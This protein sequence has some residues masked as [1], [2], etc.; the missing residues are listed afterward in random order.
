MKL[1]RSRITTEIE[2][3]HNEL[4]SMIITETKYPIE[5]VQKLGIIDFYTHVRLIEKQFKKQSNGNK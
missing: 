5:W 4:M 1:T 3:N 2:N